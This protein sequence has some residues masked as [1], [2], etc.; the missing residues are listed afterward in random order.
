[1][2]GT[3]ANSLL[4]VGGHFAASIALAASGDLFGVELAILLGVY[5]IARKRTHFGEQFFGRLEAFGSRFAQRKVA[6]PVALAAAVILLRAAILPIH[7]IP[8]PVVVDEFSHLLLA[9]TLAHSRLTNPTH[10]LW[11]S[12]ETIHVIQQ[13]TYN[14][15]Y[16]PGPAVLLW[17]GTVVAGVPWVGLLVGSGVLCGL[18]CWALQAWFPPR[19]ALLGGILAALHIGLAS[20]WVDSYWGGTF[21]AIGGTLMVGAFQRLQ[22]K[23]SLGAESVGL[24]ALMALGIG[25]LANSRPYEGFVF[26]IPVAVRLAGWLFEKRGAPLAP[27]LWRVVL[28]A[29]LCLAA[30]GA[31]MGIY[32]NAVTGSPTRIPYVV[33][34]ER[35]GWPMT[36]P[37]IEVQY[38]KHD[39]REFDDYYLYEMGDR[40]YFTSLPEFL[41]G[42]SIKVET[43]WR[44]YFGPAL[45]IP[46]L[47]IRR[48]YRSKR[49]RLLMVAGAVTILASCLTA[50]DFPHYLA[51]AMVPIAAVWVQG[52]RYLR[53]GKGENHRLGVRLS[54]AIPVVLLAII[55]LRMAASS[56][57]LPYQK[58]AGFTSWCCSSP[59]TTDQQALVRRLPPGRHLLLV[60][61]RPDHS[62]VKEWVYN[63]AD[64][65]G[66]RVV[67]ARELGGEADRKLLAYFKDRQAWIVEPDFDP[68]RVTPYHPSEQGRLA[69]AA[70]IAGQK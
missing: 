32:F 58:Y 19:W 69:A 64:I 5:L 38:V 27:K 3:L 68:P 50:F 67:W 66:S 52:Y 21:A 51:P 20:Y 59:G 31:G 24:A 45:T 12:F 1:M 26:C 39:Q 60:R 17:L 40:L 35:Y 44:F 22:K 53:Q 29:A 65:D 70:P 42:L 8:H 25:M 56:F 43:D 6:A 2:Y 11:R 34:Q 47:F 62:G 63:G 28:P 48:F 15:M 13:P 23:K 10:P 61:Y 16:F 36:L 30:I 37:W 57:D 49:L 33:N 14:S 9:D 54:R 46:F 4:Y 41:A 18:I 7:P 55:G